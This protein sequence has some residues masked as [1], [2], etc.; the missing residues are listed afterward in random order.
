MKEYPYLTFSVGGFL[1]QVA[2]CY[3]RDGDVVRVTLGPRSKC[4]LIEKKWG[5]PRRTN[6]A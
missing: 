4:V 6:R 3:L 2:V 5:K 1:Q